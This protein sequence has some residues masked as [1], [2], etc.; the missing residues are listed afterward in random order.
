MFCTGGWWKYDKRTN[1]ELEEYFKSKSTRAE[2][3][4]CANVYVI[5]FV[6]LVQYKKDEQWRKRRIKR[7][8]RTNMYKGVAGISMS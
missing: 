7:E 4:I 6:Q 8:I 3:L 5:D 2:V 1:A